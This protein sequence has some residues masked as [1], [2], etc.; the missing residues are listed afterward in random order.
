MPD[1][2]FKLPLSSYEEL[3]K[4]IKAY[5]HVSQPASLDEMSKLVGIHRTVISANA[6]FLTATGILESGREKMPTSLGRELALALGHEMPPEIR[7]F[8]RRVVEG[9]D[10]LSKL[11]AAIKIR[12]GMDEQTLQAH[13]AY[14]AGQPKKAQFMTGAR[15]VIGIL[16]AA[17]LI[18]EVDGKIIVDREPESSTAEPGLIQPLSPP[19]PQVEPARIVQS[20]APVGTRSHVQIQIQI[21]VNCSAQEVETLG[22]KLQSLISSLACAPNDKIDDNS[23]DR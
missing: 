10:F 9:N 21:N 4:I 19:I 2:K 16:R 6:G 1:E 13:I 14:S 22:P 5:G 7:R 18:K 17:E 23:E 12:N 15:T 8:W 20:V 3:V 11:L